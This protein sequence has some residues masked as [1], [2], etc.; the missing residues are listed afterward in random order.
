MTQSG[1]PS[2]QHTPRPGPGR[3]VGLSPASRSPSLEGRCTE[4]KHLA[5]VR[6][7]DEEGLDVVCLQEAVPLLPMAWLHLVVAVQARQCRLG[8][9]HLP[10]GRGQPGVTEGPALRPGVHMGPRSCGRWH[11]RP[12]PGAS[13]MRNAGDRQGGTAGW[14]QG[15]MRDTK[16]REES[17]RPAAWQV[18][19]GGAG[20]GQRHKPVPKPP[21]QEAP[22]PA[23]GRV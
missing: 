11:R 8:D 23:S 3:D 7:H 13:C 6:G 17:T 14:L 5:P 20:R 2:P 9:V 12:P 16:G 21:G 10:A 4:G 15:A 1:G 22:A 19:E 18:G